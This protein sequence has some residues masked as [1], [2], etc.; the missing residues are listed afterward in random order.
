MSLIRITDL[1]VA[2]GDHKLLDSASLVVEK[3]DR[4]G[5]IG[6]NGEGKS[7]LLN[8]LSSRIIADE[9]DIQGLDQIQI[10]AL[11]QSPDLDDQQSVFEAVASGL[12][13]IG[14][15]LVRYQNALNSGDAET[16]SSAQTSL[17]RLDGWSAET[18]IEK[19][20]ARLSLDGAE[21]VGTLSGGWK[22]RVGLAK[23]LVTEPDLLLLDEPTNHLDI[24]SITWLEKQ[25]L[26]FNGAVIVVTHDRRFLV[27]VTNR[28]VDLERGKLTLWAG[29]YEDFL[30]RKAASLQE[31]KRHNAAFDKKLAEEEAWIRQGIK[32][33]RT[34]NEGR[35]RALKKMREERALRRDRKGQVRMSLDSGTSS[36]KV[37]IE[38]ENV[39]YTYGQ[40]P[41][42]KNFSTRI[43]RGDRIGLIGPNGIGKTTLI[44]LLLGNVVPSE[45]TVKVGTNVQIAYFDQQ[46][47]QLD[48]D[49]RIIDVIGEG[50]DEITVGGKSIHVISYL[51]NFL[52]TPSRSR[53]PIR[54]LSGGEK[55]R[56][57]LASLFSKPAN[58]LVMDEPTNDL[59]I[60]TLELLEEMLLDFDG[61]LLLVSHDRTFMDNVVTSALAFEGDGVVREYVG[62]YSD[63]LRQQSQETTDIEKKQTKETPNA[64]APR[65]SVK[66]LSY[67][68]QR[69]LDQLPS[70]IDDL[71]SRQAELTEII[72]DSS[73]YNNDSDDVARTLDEL[74]TVSASLDQLYARWDELEN[75]V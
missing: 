59:D 62:G 73:F 56:V 35:V 42:V 21:S 30:R 58:V 28:I 61:T 68:L 11:D 22:R 14:R 13:P 66:K 32:A 5:L 26:K 51:S 39:S 53:S 72:S 10:A 24:E 65:Q 63:W 31:E 75:A 6:R 44:R 27:N 33:R 19:V 38:A 46:R 15:E 8:I 69:E 29:G 12:G 9:G 48:A 54:S 43:L 52:F 49:K 2:F 74:K 45:G 37:V 71:E 3:G 18:R 40:S 36:G 20:L 34:R 70:Q 47:D 4:I 41:I 55:A 1:S 17:D 64:A 23:A 60:E 67:K 7:T 57:L 50:R 25:I 16:M